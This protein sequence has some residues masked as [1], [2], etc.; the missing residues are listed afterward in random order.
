M[1]VD[2]EPHL[3]SHLVERYHALAAATLSGLTEEEKAEVTTRPEFGEA[4]LIAD[5]EEEH[6]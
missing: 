3:D 6:S 5:S 4:F 1:L 2:L